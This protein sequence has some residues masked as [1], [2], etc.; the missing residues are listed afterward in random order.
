MEDDTTLPS[1]GLCLSNN[2]R[3]PIQTVVSYASALVRAP[4]YVLQW[5]RRVSS[6]RRVTTKRKLGTCRGFEVLHSAELLGRNWTNAALSRAAGP[7]CFSDVA[8][9]F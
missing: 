2:R 4:P 9:S 5:R 8:R 3:H 6:R 7:G 1:R